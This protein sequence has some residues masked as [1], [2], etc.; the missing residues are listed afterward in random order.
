[1][2]SVTADLSSALAAAVE[3]AGA[4]VVR[5]EGRRRGPSSGTVW[6]ADGLVV[7]AHHNLERDED[8]RVGLASGESVTAEVA[9]RDPSTDLAVLRVAAS[10]LAPAEFREPGGL[11]VGHLVLGLTRPGRTVRARLGILHAVGEE[12]RTGAGAR[13]D[14]YLESDIAIH[15]AFSGGLLVD[16]AGRA[17]GLNNA[18]L[19]RGS[20]VAVPVATLRRVV[21][22]LATHGHVRRGLLGIGTLP[23]RLPTSSA[24]GEAGLLVTSVQPD[25]AAARAG[26]LIGDVLL[27]ADGAP[28]AGPMDLLPHLEEERVGL[29]LIHI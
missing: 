16:D 12:W 24:G 9:G 10:G 20:S 21:E 28:L 5:V 11:K 18:G 7:A 6:S 15:D 23:V 25:T 4:S 2:G 27:S 26:I 3:R 14:R 29:S 8:I 13:I 19:V 17:I 22:A 1:M